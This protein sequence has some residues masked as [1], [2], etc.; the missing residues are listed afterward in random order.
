[1]RITGPTARK[2]FVISLVVVMLT[3]TLGTSIA[4][5]GSPPGPPH[6]VGKTWWTGGL[7]NY[8]VHAGDTLSGI[9]VR[10]HTTVG[11]LASVNH[12]AN[13]R[14]I[15]IGQ[16]LLVPCGHAGPPGPKPKPVPCCSYRVRFGD[17]LSGIAWHYGTSVGWLASVNHIANP[18]KIY[19]GTWLRVP[20]W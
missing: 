3:V 6:E 2:V 9:A 16:H 18:S 15:R 13:P 19:A 7:C 8:W 20:C 4:S 10:Y 17:T 14:L 1:M 5:A 12:I 11:Y